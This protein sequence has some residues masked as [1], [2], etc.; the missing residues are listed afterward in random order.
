MSNEETR[1]SL[2]VK[3]TKPS[4][5]KKQQKKEANLT[6]DEKLISSRVMQVEDGFQNYYWNGS[7]GSGDVLMPPYDPY[8]LED[9]VQ[10]NNALRQCIEAYEVNIDG[11]GHVIEHVEGTPENQI[12]EAA[13][14]ALFKAPY[15]GTSMVSLRRKVRRDQESSGNGYVE[16]I[17]DLQGGVAFLQ[18]VEGKTVR[19]VKL[20]G[21]YAD[22]V[23]VIRNGVSI[24][25]Q[26]NVRNRRFVQVVGTKLVYFK[27]YGANRDLHA[28]DG[29][30]HDAGSLPVE[31]RATELLHFPCMKDTY[32]PYG[33]P[34]WTTQSPSVVGSRKAEENNVDYLD[35]GGIPPA[36]IFISGGQTGSDT[37]Q[38]LNNLIYGKGAS[39]NKIAIAEIA[40]TSGSLDSADRVD[41]KIERFGSEKAND[42]MFEN[43][44]DRC[45]KRVR[46]SF[47]L[48]PL[49]VGRTQDFSYA[50]AYA[51]YTVA[52]AQV[53]GPE[54]LMFDEVMNMLIV[55]EFKTDS[56]EYRSL[57]VSVK[58]SSVQLKALSLTASAG[59]ITNRQLVTHANELSGMNIL[60]D[61]TVADTLVSIGGKAG[62]GL[63]DGT[64]STGVET[65]SIKTDDMSPTALAK[66]WAAY[67]KG[68]LELDTD[69]QDMIRKSIAGLS[70]YSESLFTT[71][72]TAEMFPT[73]GDNLSVMELCKCALDHSAKREE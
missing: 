1:R 31:D 54:R 60:V 69:R 40:S 26:M 17:R 73:M 71:T 7:V 28:K 16:V 23:S 11:T 4:K 2:G 57:P 30:W 55:R 25:I 50:T 35:A 52:E 14:K 63:M 36:I 41:V 33:I 24:D 22:T 66:V 8:L 68:D 65:Q 43:Y 51:S 53:F 37:K 47:R 62:G 32:T 46:S 18:H 70:D 59:S 29:T 56:Y 42:S 12:I 61:D 39:K 38:Q 3:I 64:Q 15:P 5:Q 10:S 44:D 20:D 72:L 27:E 67:L 49:F 6:P 58:D 21:A 45:E 48:P 13:I 19:M 34:R 9:R